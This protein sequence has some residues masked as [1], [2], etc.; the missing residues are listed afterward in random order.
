MLGLARQI[1]RCYGVQEGCTLT[2]DDLVPGQ[3]R[4]VGW[5]DMGLGEND[6]G[7]LGPS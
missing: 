7:D 4:S 6:N 2:S 3:V 5:A 1:S